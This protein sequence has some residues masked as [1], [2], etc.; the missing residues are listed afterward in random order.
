M[1]LIRCNSRPAPMAGVAGQLELDWTY[2]RLLLNT[3]RWHDPGLVRTRCS[4]REPGVFRAQPLGTGLLSAQ[5]ASAFLRSGTRPWCV[6]AMAICR[7]PRSG[8][9]SNLTHYRLKERVRDLLSRCRPAGGRAQRPG[10]ISSATVPDA[11]RPMSAPPNRGALHQTPHGPA[12]RRR[13]SNGGDPRPL[14]WPKHRLYLQCWIRTV[15]PR[16][17]RAL[18]RTWEPAAG[19]W[20]SASPPG[21]SFALL[22]LAGDAKDS[23]FSTLL[24][25]LV[26]SHR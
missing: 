22:Q 8:P 19:T 5:A 14:P 3:R 15:R 25:P 6:F 10:G 11:G 4:P 9:I 18:P 7:N 23:V 13:T 2:H 1:N 17:A 12:C 16:C 20:R 21:Q 24:G 26:R